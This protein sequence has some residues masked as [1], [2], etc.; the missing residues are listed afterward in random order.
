MDIYPY[1]D[2]DDGDD[3]DEDDVDVEMED[4]DTE[5]VNRA[6]S[7][8]EITPPPTVLGKHSNASDA[9]FAEA[10]KKARRIFPAVK[11]KPKGRKQKDDTPPS[12]AEFPWSAIAETVKVSC[13]YFD[14]RILTCKKTELRTFLGKLSA[15]NP[16]RSSIANQDQ[17]SLVSHILLNT[18]HPVFVTLFLEGCSCWQWFGQNRQFQQCRP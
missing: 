1:T 9:E 4:S 16:L 15:S 3:E 7:D 10:T 12:I 5:D 18:Y 14:W 11:R 13:S 8:D 2:I 6:A 17:P